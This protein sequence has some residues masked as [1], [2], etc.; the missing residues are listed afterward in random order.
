VSA[1]TWRLRLA[2]LV[3]PA[4]ADVHDPDE[5]GCPSDRVVLE[6]AAAWDLSPDKDGRVRLDVTDV[7]DEMLELGW[8]ALTTD[9]EDCAIYEL[10]GPG[11][12]ELARMWGGPMSSP[13]PGQELLDGLDVPR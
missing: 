10:M 8:I 3:A 12:A 2:Q 6:A 1:R 7:A 11:R 13:L 5:T 9:H 4:G